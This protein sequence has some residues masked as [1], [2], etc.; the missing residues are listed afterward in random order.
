[1]LLLL[2]S[3]DE[4]SQGHSQRNTITQIHSFHLVHSQSTKSPMLHTTTTS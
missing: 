4:D 2:L 3:L 1:M